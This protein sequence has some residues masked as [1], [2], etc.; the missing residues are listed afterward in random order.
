MREVYKLHTR[1]KISNL[2]DRIV[3]NH[4]KSPKK[5]KVEQNLIRYGRV[6]ECKK[7]RREAFESKLREEHEKEIQRIEA[8]RHAGS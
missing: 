3:F 4:V 2:N 5:R 1:K 7:I 6:Q 8:E